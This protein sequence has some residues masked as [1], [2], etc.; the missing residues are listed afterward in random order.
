MMMG[1]PV[2]ASHASPEDKDMKSAFT[3]GQFVLT[4]MTILYYYSYN[5]VPSELRENVITS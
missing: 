3:Y 1:F 5:A 2:Y 4:N